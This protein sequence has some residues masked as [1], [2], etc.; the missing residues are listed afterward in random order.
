MIGFISW[1]T[2]LGFFVVGYVMGFASSIALA[3]FIVHRRERR[4]RKGNGH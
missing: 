3:Q 4:G 1:Q 2:A